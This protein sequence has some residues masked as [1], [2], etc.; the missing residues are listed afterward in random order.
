MGL[1][2]KVEGTAAKPSGHRDGSV[3]IGLHVQV[4]LGGMNKTQK[5]MR[6]GCR[7]GHGKGDRKGY[8]KVLFSFFSLFWCRIKSCKVAVSFGVI[9]DRLGLSLLLS[10]AL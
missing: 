10:F 3:S 5:W 9:T 4:L 2:T 6:K 7:K 1:E 8:R